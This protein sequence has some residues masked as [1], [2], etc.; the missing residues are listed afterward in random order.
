MYPESYFTTA[1]LVEEIARFRSFAR[2]RLLDVGCGSMPYR[3]LFAA[4]V[5]RHVG[6]DVPTTPHS[7]GGLAAFASAGTIPFAS[8]TFDTVL[9]SETLEHAPDPA[10]A[11]REMARVCVPGGHIL[12]STPFMY[13]VHEA[14][15]DFFRY[16]PY[17]IRR[18]AED[19]GLE[20]VEIRTRGGFLSLLVDIHFKAGALAANA[21][22]RVTRKLGMRRHLKDTAFV[23][24]WFYAFA[25]LLAPLYARENIAAD[26]YT[27]GYIF[28]LR[29]PATEMAPG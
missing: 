24:A 7:R 8:N 18:L 29:K 4:A 12:A 22:T 3:P 13:R 9:C 28:L 25:R 26:Q 5:T 21:L 16:T 11:L 27:T 2:G 23:H 14:P 20:V 10:A 19:A 6:I 1:R 17:G 15:W